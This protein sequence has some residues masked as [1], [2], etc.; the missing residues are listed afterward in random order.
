MV[1]A[2]GAGDS[3]LGALLWALV[4]NHPMPEALRYAV[5]AGAAAV[6]SPGTALCDRNEVERLRPEV[7]IEE[8]GERAGAW[9]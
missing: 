8:V 6:L 1:S 3:F 2:V 9:S 7:Q 4:S 5:A